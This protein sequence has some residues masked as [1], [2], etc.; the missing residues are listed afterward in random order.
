MCCLTHR[1]SPPIT[2]ILTDF[3]EVFCCNC[4]SASALLASPGGSDFLAAPSGR[5]ERSVYSLQLK[6]SEADHEG[7]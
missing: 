4:C 3:F 1:F 6:W 2:Q 5:A 7:Q